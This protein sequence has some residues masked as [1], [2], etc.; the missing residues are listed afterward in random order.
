MQRNQG[1]SRLEDDPTSG[2]DAAAVLAEMVLAPAVRGADGEREL[3][4]LGSS[5]CP[6]SAQIGLS[7]LGIRT[8]SSPCGTEHRS[9]W[10][11]PRPADQTQLI[12]A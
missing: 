12:W 9:S 2:S 1:S 3:L 5:T 7:S 6:E 10:P 8:V 4:R 11:V